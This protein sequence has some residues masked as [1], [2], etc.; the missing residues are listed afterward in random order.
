MRVAGTPETF[1][2]WL[3]VALELAFMTSMRYYFRR[4]HGG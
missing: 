2:L 4:Q 1:A 3:L